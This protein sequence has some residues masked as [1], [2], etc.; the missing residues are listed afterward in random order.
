MGHAPSIMDYSRFNYVAQPEDGIALEN[1]VPTIGPWDKYTIRYGYAEIPSARTWEEERPT[2]ERWLQEQDSVPWYRFSANN[3]FGFGTQ[4]EAVGD[5]DP[6]KST[7]LGFKNIER[8]MGYVVQAGTRP[9]EDNDLLRELY[10]RTVNQWA[11]EAGHPVTVIA[12]ASVQYKSGSQS[13][14]VYA[15]LSKAR[16]QEAVK[17][18][19]EQV[20]RTP[21][22]LIRPDVAARVEATGMLNRIGNAQNRV[23]TQVFN[24]ARLNRLVE[25]P[26]MNRNAYTL[27][28]MVEDVQRGV[29]SELWTS[30]P[31]IDAYR[32][33]LQNNWLRIFDGKLN[34]PATPAANAA[35]LAQFG[36]FPLVED[37]RSQL[38]G[39]LVT[40]RVAI[41][42]AT[43]RAANRETR[44]HLQAADHAIGKILDPKQ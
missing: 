29:W 20:F 30:A 39:E 44:M 12:G 14:P 9:G 24:D 22:Y 27:V 10:D 38:R 36:I 21:A 32:R 31:S 34:P 37:A 42:N 23:L 2:L 35:Q 11:T 4:S 7:G 5:A 13:G 17:F 41:R 8:V 43:S 3:A 15:P 16:Q 19:N 6:V 33:Q 40:L 1:M 25:Q 28:E 18:L 26:A